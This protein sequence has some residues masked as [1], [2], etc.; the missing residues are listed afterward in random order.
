M[1]IRD[2][3]YSPTIH[4]IDFPA[5]GVS[6]A[7]HD[8][9]EGLLV[10]QIEDG[11]KT[12]TNKKT[13]VS[14]SN[15]PD[16]NQ[17]EV[18]CDGKPFADYSVDSSGEVVLNTEVTNH[19]FHIRT[20]YILSEEQKKQMNKG[21]QYNTNKTSVEIKNGKETTTRL[22]VARSAPSLCGCC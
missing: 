6:Q 9:T 13:K 12:K 17:I 15:I 2:R 7:W 20:G 18:F 19:I 1:C 21:I 4:G 3:Y 5:V 16:T 14:V 10:F 22:L 11:D 8:D